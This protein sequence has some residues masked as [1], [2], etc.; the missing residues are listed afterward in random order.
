E[1]REEYEPLIEAGIVVYAGIDYG[2]ILERAES[3]A[4]IIIWDGGNNDTP[5]YT[6]DLHIVVFDPHRPDHE[7]LYYPGETNMIMADVAI[8]NKV[9]TASESNVE[10]VRKNIAAS[11]PRA[12]IILS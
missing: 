3:E 1:E 11:N 12:T 5:F 10:K 9:D 7:L 2:Q 4:D 8:I 6:P